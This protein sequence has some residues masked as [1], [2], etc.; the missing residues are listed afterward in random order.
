MRFIRQHILPIVYYSAYYKF[1]SEFLFDRTDNNDILS[2][3]LF[4]LIDKPSK[5]IYYGNYTF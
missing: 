3:Y 1:R 4:N 2:K 5:N